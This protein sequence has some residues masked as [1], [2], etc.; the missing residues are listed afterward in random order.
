MIHYT[1]YKGHKPNIY[2]KCDNNIYTFD[3]E[4]TSYIILNGRIY[5]NIDYLSF[6]EK[7]KKECIF[8]GFMY[9]WMFSINDTVY[10]G[11]TWE[12]FKKFL[13]RLNNNVKSK[14]I[15]FIHNL[16]FEFQ[17]LKSVFNV[18]N[19][20]ARKSHKVMKC[21]LIDY[22]IEL[23]CSYFMS[24]CALSY[25]PKLYDLPVKKMSGDLDYNKIRTPKTKLTKKEL[26]YCEN[27]CLVIYY[28]ILKMLETYKTVK[29]I[30]LTSTG[31]VRRELKERV[32]KDFVYKNKVYNAINTNPHIYNM[33]VSA[34]MGGYTHSNW[35]YTGDIL[36]DIDSYDFT[37][38]YPYVLVCY[39][40]PSS[41]FKKCT[42]EKREDMFNSFAYLLTVKLINV[43]S[44]FNNHFLSQSKCKEIVN[45]RYDNG[46]IISADSL[47]ITVTDIDFN[48]ILD[49]YNCEY[50][51]IESYY[52]KYNYLPKQFIN[53]ILEKYVNKTKL[54]NV[55][56]KE[57]EYTKEKNKFNSLYG[58]SVTNMIRDNVT[59]DNIAGWQEIELTNNE[60]IDLLNKE[61]NKAFLSFAYGVWVT[62]HARNNLIRNIMK[63][64]DYTVYSDTDSLKLLKGYDKKIIIDYNNSV[65]KRIE[66]ISKLLDINI[67][68]FSP[69]DI[70]GK[71]HTLGLF[72]KDG[73]YDEFITQGAKK[74]AYKINNKIEITVAGVPKKGALGLKTLYDFKDNFVFEYQHTGKNLLFY[75]DNQEEI[76]ITD[77]RGIECKIIDVSACCIIPTTYV[78]GKSLEY[79]NLLTENSS[80]RAVYKE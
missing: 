52:S 43:Q 78:L 18:D 7:Q 28:Y 48:L 2:R 12:D 24:N 71:K 77:Y 55:S 23:R 17:F 25:L 36:Y 15:V 37:S 76:V 14:K 19:V 80:A 22:N 11:R 63:L 4:T 1:R 46:R 29:T 56:G 41:V 69:K 74:Y 5:T 72:E 13:D 70:N 54:K 42:I 49:T 8:R 67:D 58:M 21:D 33:L 61:K 75:C 51:I 44:K 59:Y 47:I 10:Y 50:E 45:G 57:V 40:Y 26:I 64:D 79:A 35:I 73:H 16:A 53:F 60:I 62:A 32:A 30:P 31:Q 20:V 38:S 66:K 9:I 65:I 34:F 39:K 6:N 3:I 27:D 68:N